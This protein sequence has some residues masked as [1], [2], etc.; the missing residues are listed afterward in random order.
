[1]TVLT[2]IVTSASFTGDRIIGAILFEDMMTVQRYLER[3][4]SR[5]SR[6]R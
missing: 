2:R 5:Q 6:R 4:S 1:L 3:S